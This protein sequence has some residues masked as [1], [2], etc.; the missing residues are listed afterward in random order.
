M[1][2]V[3]LEKLT[4]KLQNPKVHPE[5]GKLATQ[6][7]EHAYDQYGI[8]WLWISSYRSKQEQAALYSIGRTTQLNRKP[9]TNAKP[10]TS[11]HNYGYAADGVPLVNGKAVWNR[12]DLFLK[13]GENAEKIGL[14]YVANDPNA[15]KFMKGDLGHIEK[16]FGL[17]IKELQQGKRAPGTPAG[18]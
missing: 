12:R 1:D 6:A 10:G 2:K 4:R 11:Y 13:F 15:G 18:V 17:S 7:T 16:N 3:K 5:F 8:E 9:V 14:S